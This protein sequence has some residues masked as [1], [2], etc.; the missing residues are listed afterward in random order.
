MALPEKIRLGDMLIHQKLISEDQLNNALEQQKSV[1]LKLGRI[2]VNSGFVSEENISETLAKQLGI[3]F[4]DLEKCLI[5]PEV[6]R[7]IP[8]YAARRLQTIVLED[9]QGKYLIGMADPTDE[10]AVAEVS[11]M[12]QL[13]VEVGVVTEGQVLVGIDR[14]YWHTKE[15]KG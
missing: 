6:V 1:K 12:L 7:L 8:E 15:I 5:K 11:R 4:L 3:E 14:G 13:K 10:K 2:L 9:R